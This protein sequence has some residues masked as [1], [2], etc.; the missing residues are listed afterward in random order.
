MLPVSG[1]L[2]PDLGEQLSATTAALDLH[3]H[4]IVLVP[5][6]LGAA[7]RRRLHTIRAI[8]ES[9]RIAL[10]E[11]D[12]PP[13]AVALLALQ[14]RRLTGTDLGPG[15]VAGAARLLTYYL[16]AG[17]VLGSVTRLDRVEVDLKSHL[18]SWVPGAQFAVMANPEAGLAEVGPHTRV[19]GPNFLTHLAVAAHGMHD[20]WVRE[21]L[22][23]QWQP[24]QVH[25][26]PLPA[27]STQWWGNHK[28][29][30]FAAY[31]PDIGVLYRLV[32][33]V[34]RES[35]AWCGL[36]VIGDQCLFCS[37]QIALNEIGLIG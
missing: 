12:L 14:L 13:L 22:A 21:D 20:D 17:A 5:A 8:L 36:E 4:L 18:R 24:G 35:C 27:A 30:E 32:T 9:D 6:A 3:G 11:T 10:V 16:Y 37:A 25:E 28:L 15:V 34:R 29:V 23:R 31:I 2:L 1:D 33:S 19:A 26:V 7:G